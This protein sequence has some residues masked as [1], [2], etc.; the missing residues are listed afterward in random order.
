MTNKREQYSENEHSLLYNETGGAC[1]LCFQ[2][3][4][5]QKKGSKK[6]TKGYELAHIY[7]LNPT[8]SQKKSLIDRPPPKEINALDNVIAL[9]PN[10]HTRYDK[11]FQLHEMDRLRQIKDKFLADGR[12]K[13]TASR[14]VIQN[15]VCDILDNILN[16]DVDTPPINATHF[17]ISTIDKKLKSGM[18]PLQKHEIKQNAIA[19]YVSIRDYIHDLE[20]VDQ[21]AVRILQQQIHTYYLEMQ[22]QHPDNKDVVFNFIAQW[23][24]MRT[25]R[26]ILA[27]QV[28]TSFFVQN[29]EVFD[30]S[31]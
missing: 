26:S 10:C 5:Y 11:D 3:V 12:A 7:P 25:G 20:Q 16:T 14:Y 18:S 6:L 2:P 4:L 15:E 1:P 30:A 27:S 22:K 19:F 28:L 13:E 9:C 24:S 17:D 29:C 23:I 8:E 31:T 21:Y